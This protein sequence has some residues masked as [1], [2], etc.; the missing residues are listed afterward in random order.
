[1]VVASGPVK[2]EEFVDQ[3]KKLFTN[4]STDPTTAS[5]LIAKGP[6]VFTGSEVCLSH[7]RGL[8]FSSYNNRT[9]IMISLNE[10]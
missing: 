1:M 8:V 9:I 6:S 2:H 10:N 7:L 4:L 5:Q 3:V